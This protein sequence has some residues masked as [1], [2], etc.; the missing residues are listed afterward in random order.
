[1]QR[2]LA[3]QVGTVAE[4]SSSTNTTSTGDSSQVELTTVRRD[5]TPA[6]RMSYN[7]SA[8]NGSNGSLQHSP[9]SDGRPANRRASSPLASLWTWRSKWGGATSPSE[10]VA[11]TAD[12]S[13]AGAATGDLETSSDSSREGDSSSRMQQWQQDK[14]RQGAVSPGLL[15][16]LRTGV[17]RSAVQGLGQKGSRSRR[18]T[19]DQNDKSV[20][21][22]RR[23]RSSLMYG[24]MVIDMGVHQLSG[25]VQKV[26]LTQV[27]SSWAWQGL[28][29]GVD[30]W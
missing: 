10:V 29:L 30:L 23:R 6:R 21:V 26:N 14:Q 12:R 24:V 25:L 27:G 9:D 20:H 16:S 4:A 28:W 19:Y 13:A 1:M 11:G 3:A 5:V 7:V 22:S 17:W 15:A 8:N 2:P 18:Y